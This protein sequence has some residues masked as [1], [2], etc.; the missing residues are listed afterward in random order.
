M[1]RPA[2]KELTERE[3]EIMHIFWDKG[4]LTAPQVRDHLASTGA[5]WP[6]RLW[7]R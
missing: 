3:L 6:T 1:A 2:A 4:E 5:T 7:L